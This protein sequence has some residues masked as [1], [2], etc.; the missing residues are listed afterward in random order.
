MGKNNKKP[1]RCGIIMPISLQRF[2]NVDYPPEYWNSMLCFLKDAITKAGYEPVAMWEDPNISS[3]TPRIVKNIMELPLAVCVISAFNPN[4]MMELGMRLVCNKPVLVIFDEHI[5]SIP[6]DIKDLEAYQLPAH[7]IYNQYPSI[8]EKISEYLHKMDKQGYKCLLDN[9]NLSGVI[10]SEGLKKNARIG[11]EVMIEKLNN[12][13]A[14][15]SNLEVADQAKA[16]TIQVG[17]TGPSPIE[18]IDMTLRDDW[19]SK[20]NKLWK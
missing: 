20:A 12:L 4:V 15:L 14:R 10:S 6:F 7:P 13:D 2:G 11:A 8:S 1:K 19:L 3:I 5:S 9:Y 17:P 16:S 18:S